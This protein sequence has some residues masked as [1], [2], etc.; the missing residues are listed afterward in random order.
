L[1]LFEG[2]IRV[3][4]KSGIERHTAGVIGATRTRQKNPE[5]VPTL[6]FE[7]AFF[8]A[9]GLMWCMMVLRC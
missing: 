7:K 6:V 9:V 8:K 5:D 1:P 4:L 2:L 3:S